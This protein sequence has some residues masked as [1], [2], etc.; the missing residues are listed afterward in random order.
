[1]IILVSCVTFVTLTALLRFSPL[2]SL[3]SCP[4]GQSV[5]QLLQW[6][7]LLLIN[8]FEL[9]DEV[10]KMFERCVEMSFLAERHNLLQHTKIIGKLSNKLIRSN[11]KVLVI[12]MGVN[13]E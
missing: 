2:L 10:D 12:N 6:S 7:E 9:L 11:L 8:Q 3:C 13:S 1:M 4:R 5:Y